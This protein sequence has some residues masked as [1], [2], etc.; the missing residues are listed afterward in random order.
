[1]LEVMIEKARR[2]VEMVSCHHAMYGVMAVVYA[3]AE[4]HLCDKALVGQVAMW[5][6][7]T[8]AVRPG[9]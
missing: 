1:M 9:H 3:A 7:A 5:V 6:Y 2:L 4:L 8:L